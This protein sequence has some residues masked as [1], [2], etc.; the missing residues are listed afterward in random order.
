M[1]SRNRHNRAIAAIGTWWLS[2]VVVPS[3]ALHYGRA[4]E[5]DERNGFQYTA[6]M[7]WRKAAELFAPNT[8]PAQYFWCQWERIMHLPRRLAGPI[9]ASQPPA[10]SLT[11]TSAIA[12]AITPDTD[13]ISFACSVRSADQLIP[14]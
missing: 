11:N 4:A 2:N 8:R 5:R 3:K 10:F 13:Q 1:K 12:P 14:A 6:A 7:E 9:G